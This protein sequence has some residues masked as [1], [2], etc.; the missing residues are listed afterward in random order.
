VP[1]AANGAVGNTAAITQSAAAYRLKPRALGSAS[2]ANQLPVR[3]A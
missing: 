1:R 3:I 2:R